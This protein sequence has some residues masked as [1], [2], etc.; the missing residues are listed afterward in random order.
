M[1]HALALLLATILCLPVNAIKVHTIGD[2][3]MADYNP[4]ATDKRGWGTYFGLFFNPEY[5]TVNNRGKSGASTRTFY[6]Q[7][8]LWAT[9]KTQMSAGDYVLIQFAHNDEKCNGVDALELNDYLTAHGQ[10]AATDLRGTCPSTTYKANLRRYTQML[11]M[12][13]YTR[14]H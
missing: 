6:D 9:V 4:S 11:I 13:K 10:P 3:T 8:N 5:V 12:I 1:K 2:S 7:P 14:I